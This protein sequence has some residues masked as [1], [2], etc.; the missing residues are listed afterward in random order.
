MRVGLVSSCAPLVYGGGRN[1]VDWLQIKLQE[2]GQQSEV[3][4]IPNTDGPDTIMEQMTA[5]RLLQ[6]EDY[7]DRVITFRPPSHV[8]QHSN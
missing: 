8:V 6:L 1:I 7:F 3:I 2:H 4:Y 5:F